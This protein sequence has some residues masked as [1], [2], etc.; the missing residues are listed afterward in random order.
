MRRLNFY[1]RMDLRLS[2]KRVRALG[3]RRKPRRLGRQRQADNDKRTLGLEYH[4]PQALLAVRATDN[5]AAGKWLEGPSGEPPLDRT[6][7]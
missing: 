4:S 3:A 2:G 6:A 7:R 1:R 5:A